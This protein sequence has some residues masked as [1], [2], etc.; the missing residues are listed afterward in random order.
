MKKNIITTTT[1]LLLSTSLVFGGIGNT[2][3]DAEVTSTENYY[4]ESNPTGYYVPK[5]KLELMDPKDIKELETTNKLVI[6]GEEYNSEE[7]D[8][9]NGKPLV[10]YPHDEICVGL[11]YLKIKSNGGFVGIT[12]EYISGDKLNMKTLFEYYEID[13]NEGLQ[14]DFLTNGNINLCAS[15]KC[16][17]Q[18]ELNKKY[19]YKISDSSGTTLLKSGKFSTYNKISETTPTEFP[20]Y[21]DKSDLLKIDYKFDEETGEYTYYISLEGD[22]L[23]KGEFKIYEN[24]KLPIKTLPIYKIDQIDE[25]EHKKSFWSRL[26]FWE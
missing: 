7:L 19:A 2:G 4:D 8:E 6:E 25:L 17:Y 10:R 21:T 18:I 20:K 22:T 15:S 24:D 16:K 3:N 23:K 1:L 14:G 26:R 9:I 13:N 11:C 5:H 12:Y